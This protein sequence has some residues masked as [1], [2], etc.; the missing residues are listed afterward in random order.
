MRVI[1]VGAG[2][3][4]CSIA[5]FVARAGAEVTLIDRD[6][7]G[8]HAS[9]AAAGMLAPQAE[10][11]ASN[12]FL[13]L[14]LKGRSL[15]PSLAAELLAE[16][17]IDIGYRT[18]GS[19]LLAL[20]GEDEESLV[21]RYKWQVQGGLAVESL[22]PEDV[23]RLEPSLT[24]S[25]RAALLL[26]DDHQVENRL[27]NAAL[28]QSAAVAGAELIQEPV[29]EVL[30]ERGIGV[31]LASGEE[32]RGDA[33]VIA[34]GSWSGGIRGLPRALPVEPVPGQLLAYRPDP[35]PLSHVVTTHRGYLV[36]RRDG[37]LIAGAT[38]EDP[39]FEARTTEEGKEQVS[40]GAAEMLPMLR[41]LQVREHWAGL[42]PATPD[43]LPILGADPDVR[44][45]FYAT[46]HYRNGVLLAPVTGELIGRLILGVA[47]G[48]DL[49][50]FR[51]DR[52]ATHSAQQS[53][54]NG[55]RWKGRPEINSV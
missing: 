52:F 9:W 25:V 53:V 16:T 19:L 8:R 14:L 34:A 3:I 42:R 50:P 4:G 6:E 30:T 33:V 20:T 13:S 21:G 7:P 26:P 17:G 43:R 55:F 54:E 44:G 36:P 11:D 41:T 10:A 2:L 46:G 27:L 12:D 29:A 38:V 48:S 5:R 24:R 35:M 49:T 15:Y 18:E 23:L 22:T 28:Q 45:L 51:V 31:R 1:V 47:P 37:R 32:L 39:S 40:A